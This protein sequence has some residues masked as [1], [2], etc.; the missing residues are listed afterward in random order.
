MKTGPYYWSRHPSYFGWFYWAIGTQLLM[1]NY[2]CLPLWIFA[3]WTFFNDRIP[4]EEYYLVRF[5]G[6]EYQE[7]AE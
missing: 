6:E 5:F 1:S 4:T 7:Y 3:A 2:V